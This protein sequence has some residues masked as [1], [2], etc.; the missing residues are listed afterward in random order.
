[1]NYNTPNSAAAFLAYMSNL[2]AVRALNRMC[3]KWHSVCILYLNTKP[4]KYAVYK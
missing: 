1:M 4:R 2:K 3:L